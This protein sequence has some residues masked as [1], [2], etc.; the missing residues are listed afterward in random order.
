M[1]TPLQCRPHQEAPGRVVVDIRTMMRMYTY[2]CT[3]VSTY[4]YTYGGTRQAGLTLRVLST[5]KPL[6]GSCSSSRVRKTL[7]PQSISFAEKVWV[8]SATHGTVT[9]HYLLISLEVLPLRLYKP[10]LSSL[11]CH[12][13]EAAYGINLSLKRLGLHNIAIIIV[14]IINNNSYTIPVR[15]LGVYRD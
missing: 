11:P 1:Q 8:E 7:K 10:S 2:V 13:M 4:M 14:T 15:R 5:R 9:L 3:Y 6:A 12:Q